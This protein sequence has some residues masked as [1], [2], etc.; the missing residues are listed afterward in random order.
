[1]VVEQETILDVV[2]RNGPLLPAQLAKAIGTDILIASAHL[3]YL[4]DNMIVLISNT[5]VGASPVYYIEGQQQKLQDFVSNL[6]A[7]DQKTFSLLKE[8]KV[9]RDDKQDQ[10]TR[11]SLRTIKDFAVPLQVTRNKEKILFWKL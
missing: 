2:R 11:L 9:L 6:N 8:R 1:M 7:K 10:L 4:V 3:S 5:K